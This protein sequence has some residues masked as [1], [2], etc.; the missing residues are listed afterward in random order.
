VL[1][2]HHYLSLDPYMRGRMND[3]KSYAA[4]P[5]IGAVMVGGT[6]GEVVESRNAAFAAGDNVV[7]MGGWQQYSGGR[8]RR[9]AMLRKVDTTM[10]RCRPTWARWACPASPP[11]YGLTMIIQPKAGETVVVSAASGAVGSGGPAGQGPRLPCGGHRRRRREVRL[12]WTNWAST[13]AS[14]TRQHRTCRVA[15]GGP[16]GGLRRT[17][18]TATSRTWAA[19]ARRGDAANMNAF[20]RIALCGMI[21]GYNGE[22]MPLANRALILSRRLKLQGFIVSEHMSTGPRR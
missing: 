10:C 13:P 21:S 6:V 15:V 11:G 12:R 1:V 7:G 17:A 16:Q 8:C 20:G 3:G 14:T 2:R 19:G 4:A 18:S 9:R 5:A 22:P